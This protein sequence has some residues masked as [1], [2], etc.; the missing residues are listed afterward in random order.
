MDIG[1]FTQPA[2]VDGPVADVRQASA[3]REVLKELGG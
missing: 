2:T 1:I 3:T